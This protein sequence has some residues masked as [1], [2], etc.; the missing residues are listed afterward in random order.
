MGI[1]QTDTDFGTPKNKN[2]SGTWFDEN[3]FSFKNG[4]NI[5]TQ[6]QAPQVIITRVHEQERED[7]NV[8]V[9]V[10]SDD[11]KSVLCE[12]LSNHNENVV[13][14]NQLES[15]CEFDDAMTNEPKKQRSLRKLK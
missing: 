14:E 7:E 1:H 12:G 9:A 5:I 2:C 6:Y 4:S 15:N 3:W 10:N 13:G 11:E 8:V